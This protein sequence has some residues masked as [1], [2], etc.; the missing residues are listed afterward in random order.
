[1][2]FWTTVRYG[3]LTWLVR[4]GVFT[5]LVKYDYYRSSGMSILQ[6]VK[7]ASWQVGL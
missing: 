3:L 6:S 4:H 5:W 7:K 1:V 2:T